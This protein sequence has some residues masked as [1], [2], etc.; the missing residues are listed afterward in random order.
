MKE[1]TQGMQTF[2]ETLLEVGNRI[3]QFEGERNPEDVNDEYEALLRIQHMFKW[4]HDL[5]HFSVEG[6]KEHLRLVTDHADL[7][8]ET[9]STDLS[10]RQEKIMEVL[11]SLQEKDTAQ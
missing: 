8:K 3:E 5:D 7:T 1:E 11:D 6:M 9:F 2:R 4:V 10:R